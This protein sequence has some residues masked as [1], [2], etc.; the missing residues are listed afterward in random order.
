MT[1]LECVN[2]EL[3]GTGCVRPP[4]PVEVPGSNHAL[5]ADMVIAAIGNTPNPADPRHDGGVGG[6][7]PRLSGGRRGNHAYYPGR[8]YTPGAIL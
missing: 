4:P 5:E 1:A 7:P 8:G 3:G 2:M 6:Q